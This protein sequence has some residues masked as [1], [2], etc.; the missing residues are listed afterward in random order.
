M[1]SGE[2]SVRWDLHSCDSH[3]LPSEQAVERHGRL[4]AKFRAKSGI[5]RDLVILR[6]NS[7]NDPVGR[8]HL[9]PAQNV[10]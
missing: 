1:L 9:G 2:N 3:C 4:Q 5:S 7:R 10:I 6:L 8:S